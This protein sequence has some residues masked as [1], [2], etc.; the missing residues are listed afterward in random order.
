M[1]N[2][3]RDE[4][5]GFTRLTFDFRGREAYLVLPDTPRE[6]KKWTYKTE[7]F[8]AFPSF[9][10]EML[11]RGYYLAHL[12][13]ANRWC[14]DEDTD[15]RPEFCDFLIEEF[16]L[17]ERCF[18]IGFSCGGMQAVYFAAKYP[19]YVS[20]MY[21]DAPVLNLLSCPCGMGDAQKHR[22]PEFW[23][24]RKM[25]LAELINFR[26]HPIDN[27]H[28]LIENRIPV[29]LV[30]GD[31]DTTVPYHENGKYFSEKYK[32]T[33]VPFLEIIKPGCNHHPH[34]L[35]DNTPLIEFAEKYYI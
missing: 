3:K 27:V 28:K 23:S 29:A 12:K 34:G 20:A 30:C 18:P 16:G 15:M 17:Y 6:D 32:A 11:K 8:D 31:S 25:T 2:V 5:Q 10:I 26:N 13:N 33:D 14:P 9:Q 21:I 22:F 1:I 7:Y 19:K 24:Y 4:W 35:E